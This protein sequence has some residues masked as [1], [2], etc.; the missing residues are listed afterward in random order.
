MTFSDDIIEFGD[1]YPLWML[2]P[3]AGGG[4]GRSSCCTLGELGSTERRD[5]SS[6][7][8]RKRTALRVAAGRPFS[9]SHRDRREV[10]MTVPPLLPALPPHGT[11]AGE[12]LQAASI[13]AITALVA[14]ALSGDPAAVPFVVSPV[15][16]ALRLW[17]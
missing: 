5:G 17:G 9:N 4:S 13:V 12:R 7:P 1:V 15:L 3:R 11:R 6:K 10:D 16:V 2:L 8:A 14:F